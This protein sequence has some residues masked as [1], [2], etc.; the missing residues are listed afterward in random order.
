MDIVH[1]CGHTFSHP[2]TV[3]EYAQQQAKCKFCYMLED[4]PGMKFVD[5]VGKTGK[6]IIELKLLSIILNKTI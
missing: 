1:S 5:L 4:R 3:N 6:H 2:E